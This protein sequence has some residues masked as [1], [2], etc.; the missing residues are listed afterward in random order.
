[1]ENPEKTPVYRYVND[2]IVVD[3]ETD[4][5]L[6]K[7]QKVEVLDSLIT[8]DTLSGVSVKVKPDFSEECFICASFLTSIIL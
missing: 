2:R 4:F 5:I 8:D 1:M 7:G 6:E 3:Y